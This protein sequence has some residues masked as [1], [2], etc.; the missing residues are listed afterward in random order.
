MT[1]SPIVKI[2]DDSSFLM[3]EYHPSGRVHKISWLKLINGAQVLHKDFSY[4]TTE[5][6]STC[7][8][9][10][11][12]ESG[13]IKAR[14]WW[15]NGKRTTFGHTN[16][17]FATYFDTDSNTTASCGYLIHETP[18]DGVDILV[19]EYS[20]QGSILRNV[21]KRN[22]N[23]YHTN[24]PAIITFENGNVVLQEWV[25]ERTQRKYT[26]EDVMT[27][28]A[29][30]VL[31]V[32]T[33]NEFFSQNETIVSREFYASERVKRETFR[34]EVYTRVIDYGL[35]GQKTRVKK[36]MDLGTVTYLYYKVYSSTGLKFTK[37]WF[38]DGNFHRES[39][40][41]IIE[42]HPNGVVK[43]EEFLHNGIYSRREAYQVFEFYFNGQ[44]ASRKHYVGNLKHSVSDKPAVERFYEDGQIASQ[45]WF[46]FGQ[47]HRSFMD[48]PAEILYYPNGCFQKKVWYRHGS[49]FRTSGFFTEVWYKPSYEFHRA[50]YPNGDI[51]DD[52]E[53]VIDRILSEFVPEQVG[54]P[55]HKLIVG[56][57][58]LED[59][60][61]TNVMLIARKLIAYLDSL[62][63]AECMR[64]LAY[65][66]AKGVFQGGTEFQAIM[67]DIQ[68]I[69]FINDSV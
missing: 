18:E 66:P 47:K 38:R 19:Y 8:F 4:T 33:W 1:Q 64:E 63:F 21:W 51:L 35:D 5:D 16:L 14:E 25:N 56:L 9:L 68:E 69:G 44:L 15:R 42:Y 40:P 12:Y 32:D 20:Q 23:V 22:D 45:E 39:L 55:K 67:N 36:S 48:K 3:T 24:A 49:K 13:R 58:R 57:S 43:R 30:H 2:L 50:Q 52:F 59:L 29:K 60:Y 46:N 26:F 6:M 61:I 41:A 37:Q 28:L 7:A 10:E 31:T 27:C 53:K 17:C 34:N 11:Y 54:H 62:P 65:K